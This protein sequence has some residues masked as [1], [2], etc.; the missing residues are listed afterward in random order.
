MTRLRL[1]SSNRS[2]SELEDTIV[3]LA[4]RINVAQ[5][6]FLTAIREFDTRQGWRTCGLNSCTEWLNLRC[7]IVPATAREKLR[8]AHALFDLPHLSNAFAQGELSYSNVRAL[9]RAANPDNEE[10]LARWAIGKTALQV[11][12]HSRKLRNVQAGQRADAQRIQEERSLKYIIKPDGGVA[13]HL[14]LPVVDGETILKAVELASCTD[15]EFG[16]TTFTQ[17]Q[18]DALV[19]V[20]RCYL[21]GGEQRQ[22]SPADIYQVVVHVDEIA[23]CDPAEQGETNTQSDL[24]INN[25]KK[26]LCDSSLLVVLDDSDGNPLNLGR[27]KRVVSTPLRRALISRDKSCRYPGCTHKKWLEAH[28]VTHWI[29]GGETK[30]DNL[31]LLCSRHHDLL[32]DGT[33][34]L[35]TNSSGEMYFKTKAGRVLFVGGHHVR[36]ATALYG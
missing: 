2:L 29:N 1:V 32:H 7:G 33:I 25:I 3:K 36:E 16:D 9:T 34:S 6:E 11:E 13:I 24:P 27:K 19:N 15:C 23:L 26:L 22:S 5:H 28:H 20:A 14:D 31:L 10:S 30:I 4:E 21:A 8:T 35:H 17:Q 18:A 12:D